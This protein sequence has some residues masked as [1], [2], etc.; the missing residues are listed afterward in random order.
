MVEA[1]QTVLADATSGF[2]LRSVVLDAV[3]NGPE[4]PELRND[5]LAILA[6]NTCPYT[7]RYD[8]FDAL[9]HVIPGGVHDVVSVFR[10]QLVGNRSTAR[11]R[12]KILAKLYP[13]SLGIDDLIAVFDDI[14]NDPAEHVSGELWDLTSTVPEPYMPEIISALCSL[15]VKREGF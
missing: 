15:L 9:L 10:N 12:A 1:F 7:E 6:D 8:A 13:D 3:R 14:L 4:V 5:L 2:H 11:L